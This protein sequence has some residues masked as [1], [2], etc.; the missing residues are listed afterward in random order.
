MYRFHGSLESQGR[1]TLPRLV[2]EENDRASKHIPT[3][4]LTK[5]FSIIIRPERD[6]F[7]GNWV[8]S[9]RLVFGIIRVRGRRNK[10]EE[11]HTVLAFW[12]LSKCFIFSHSYKKKQN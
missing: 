9:S 8:L 4:I 2:L 5:R 7:K 10:G 6:F 3:L 12:I 1:T 11:T